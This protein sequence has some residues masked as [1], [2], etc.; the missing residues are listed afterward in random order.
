LNIIA[1]NAGPGIKV[2]NR[3]SVN[4]RGN[5]IAHNGGLGIDLVDGADRANGVT[6][7]DPKDADAYSGPNGLLNFPKLTSVTRTA[8][9]NGFIHQVSGTYSGPPGEYIIIDIYANKSAD[10]SGFG[11]GQFLIHSFGVS[12]GST[13]RATFSE[14]FSTGRTSI[15][16]S[17]LGTVYTSQAQTN[18][19]EFG[20]QSSEFSNAVRLSTSIGGGS[21]LFTAKSTES[22]AGIRNAHSTQMPTLK[23]FSES[24]AR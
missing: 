1:H 22:R 3:S 15:F 23:A 19:L 10:E 18:S 21:L 24:A 9:A 2:S 6:P 13:G 4:T 11:E 5:F 20:D 17:P 8:T 16:G 12:I 7:N 14:T